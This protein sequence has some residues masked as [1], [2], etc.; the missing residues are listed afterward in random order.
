M[1]ALPALMH[2]TIQAPCQGTRRVP[3]HS[4][5]RHLEIAEGILRYKKSI[6]AADELRSFPNIVVAPMLFQPQFREGNVRYQG[7]KLRD[8]LVLALDGHH[9]N[10]FRC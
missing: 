5:E 1:K 3:F 6:E 7:L 2:V 9:A 4:E 8:D 10:V